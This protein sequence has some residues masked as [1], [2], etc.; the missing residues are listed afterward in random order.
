MGSNFSCGISADWL[1][2]VTVTSDEWVHADSLNE[3]LDAIDLPEALRRQISFRDTSVPDL[4][5]GPGFIQYRY[6]WS[7]PLLANGAGVTVARPGCRVRCE[8]RWGVGIWVPG[9]LARVGF[10]SLWGCSVWSG[11]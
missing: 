1:S 7:W 10:R 4:Q 8:A 5:R 3:D 9:S 2:K 11:W 6:S